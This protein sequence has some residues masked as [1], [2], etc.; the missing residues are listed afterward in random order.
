MR[1]NVSIPIEDQPWVLKKPIHETL[2]IQKKTQERFL[3]WVES[4]ATKKEAAYQKNIYD[5]FLETDVDHMHIN[6]TIG[7][8]FEYCNTL[9]LATIIWIDPF[10]TIRS[11][12]DSMWLA[13]IQYEKVHG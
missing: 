12:F 4:K 8:L 10:P 9:E 7:F 5:W 3:K 1:Y 11:F 13:M 6:Q 2:E